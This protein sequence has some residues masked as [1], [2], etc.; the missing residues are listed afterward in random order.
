MSTRQI[1][2]KAILPGRF[3]RSSQYSMDELM[4][5]DV[6]ASGGIDGFWGEC[7]GPKLKAVGFDPLIAEVD[8]LNKARGYGGIRYEAALVG[9]HDYDMLFPPS[10]RQNPIASKDNSSFQETSA[11]R[12][13]EAM[14]MNYIKEVFNA[15]A[16]VQLSDRLVSLNE[17]VQQSGIRSVDFVKIDTDGH[18]IEVILG[19]KEMLRTQE[20][21]GIS[22]ESQM[23]GAAHPYSNT[24]ANIDRLL[25]EWGFTL[26][27]LDLWRYSRRSLPD[28]FY[29]KIP[30]QTITG[31]VQWGEALYFRDLARPDYE[32]MHGYAATL[33]KKVK[34]ACL[35]EVY[36]LPDCSAQILVQ[37]QE[38]TGDRFF[39]TLLDDLVKNY[40]GSRMSYPQFLEHFDADP[41][42]FFPS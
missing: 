39:S 27:D 25:R 40:R 6:G 33:G 22:I 4:L 42:R 3:A 21:L 29:Y 24:F 34:L 26:F 38:Q 8:R 41:K 17:Y 7:F 31:Q 23:H 37:L 32:Q 11:V 2:P 13:S 18:D 12:A 15:G 30:A 35:F 28:K 9:S 14:R 19:A 1:N 16:E 36:G 20:V 5:I 10:L